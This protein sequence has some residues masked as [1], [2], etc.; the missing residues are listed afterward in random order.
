MKPT[1]AHV[2]SNIAATSK[3]THSLPETEKPVELKDE[4]AQLGIASNSIRSKVAKWL[5]PDYAS[6]EP[7]KQSVKLFSGTAKQPLLRIA[8]R[9]QHMVAKKREDKEMPMVL[10]KKKER[11]GLLAKYL[12]K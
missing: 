4:F 6:A 7:E 10:A 8:S 11:G 3:A 9:K 2:H 5:S 12:S 1:P